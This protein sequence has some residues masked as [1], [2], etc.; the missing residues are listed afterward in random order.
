MDVVFQP[1][2]IENDGGGLLA[3]YNTSVQ[4]VMRQKRIVEIRGFCG[5]AC[6]M[7]LLSPQTCVGPEAELWF[8][9]AS[10]NYD[11][12]RP[13]PYGTRFMLQHYP[14]KLRAWIRRQGGLVTTSFVKLKGTALRR[15]LP[16]C[17]EPNF[18]EYGR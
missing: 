9:A 10:Y 5:S 14:R 3:R 13:D 7:Y 18:K 12:G 17:K 16:G 1:L 4:E 11:P 8:H 6:T 15:L 2:I